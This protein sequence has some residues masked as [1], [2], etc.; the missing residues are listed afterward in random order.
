MG[1]ISLIAALAVAWACGTAFAQ[2]TAP[3]ITPIADRSIVQNGTTDPIT[4]TIADTQ[5]AAVDLIVTASSS[6]PGLFPQANLFLGGTQG[7][8]T[9]CATPQPNQTGSGTITVTV[10]DAGGLT[11]SRSFLVSV[12]AP[13]PPPLVPTIAST[14]LGDGAV[15]LDW[16]AETGGWYQAEYSSDLATWRVAGPAQRAT[17]ASASWTDDGTAT[18]AHPSA[19]PGRYYRLRVLGV[20]TV[21][22]NGRNFTYTDAN[23]TVT[24]IHYQP[25]G[26]GTFPACLVSHG[27]GG[28]APGYSAMKA[29]EFLAWG[30]G[31]V[32][33][34]YAHQNGGDSSPVMSGFSP[35]NLARALACRNILSTLAW[36]D[37][38]RVA[39]WGHSKGAWL[40][41]GL[42]GVIG[43]RILAAGNSAGGVIDDS[44]GADQATPTVTQASTVKAPWIM[45]HGDGD[46]VVL[47]AQSA[48]Y[49]QKLTERGIPNFR[50]VYITNQHNLH[51]D[52]TI[53]ADMIALYRSWL[54]TYGVLSP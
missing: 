25:T 37:Q 11:A 42:A 10:T 32:G 52:A 7:T 30:L 4:F 41:I 35:E 31:S 15:R 5:T 44:A 43:D 8:R 48:L 33:P 12:R 36:V 34:N 38:N 21:T 45:F 9:V 2:N 20:F 16:P 50:K 51:Q 47:P 19:A 3:T 27:Q 13:A 23:R 39:L 49:E 17:G 26:S 24:G 29:N 18:G 6:N 28:T 54:V 53:N 46:T 40:T 22:F 14:K 1:R